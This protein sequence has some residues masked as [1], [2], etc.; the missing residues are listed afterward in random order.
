[1]AYVCVELINGA[2]AVWAEQSPIIPPLSI[3]E[4]LSLG[5]RIVACW[6]VAWGLGFSARFLLSH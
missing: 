1:M 2:C 6:F 3:A 4:G 5:W